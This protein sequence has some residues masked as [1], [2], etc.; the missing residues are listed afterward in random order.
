M[1]VS[2]ASRGGGRS[3]SFSSASLVGKRVW[4]RIFS[5]QGRESRV[6]ITMLGSCLGGKKL[7]ELTLMAEEIQHA[8]MLHLSKTFPRALLG[9]SFCTLNCRR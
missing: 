5:L 8:N 2:T 3:L 4:V 7:R 9:S 6:K 1:V